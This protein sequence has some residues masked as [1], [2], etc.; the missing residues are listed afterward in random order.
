MSARRAGG[1]SG[2][3]VGGWPTLC[4]VLVTYRAADFVTDCLASLVDTTYPALRMIVVDNTSPDGT[5]G[6]VERWAR[7]PHRRLSFEARTDAGPASPAACDLTLVRAAHNDG[8]AAGVNRGLA[9]ATA[10]PTCDHVWILNPDTVVAP[11]T[12][13]ALVRHALS[14]GQYAVIGARV[15]YHARPDVVQTDGGRLHRLAGTAV[16]VNIGASARAACPPDPATLAY[17]PGVSMLVS[18]DFLAEVGPM[19]EHWFLYF[20]EI[21]WQLRRG[22]LPLGVAV[23]AVVHHRAGASIGSHTVDRHAS[24]LSVYFTC[25]NLMP[26]VRRWAWWKLPFAYAMAYYKLVRQWGASRDNVV[27]A[28]RGLHGLSPPATIR[29]KVPARAWQRLASRTDGALE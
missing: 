8:F 19:R 4:V 25:R 16:S 1:G 22:R 27:A 6:V 3:P 20:E 13:F 23:D 29:D 10:D 18:R 12:P 5:A 9:V 14:M 28:L 7:C 2:S 24:E 15:V 21:D 11:D 26:F 17:I